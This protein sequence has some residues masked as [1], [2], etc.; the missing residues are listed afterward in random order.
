MWQRLKSLF[1]KE[2]LCDEAFHESLEML[3]R[4]RVMFHDAV[5]SLR[6]K[7]SPEVDIYARD[8]MINRF[9]RRVRRMIVSHLAIATNPDITS[10]LVLTA[11]IIDI[12]R[13]GDFTKNI[14]E[15][16]SMHAEA[17]DGGE[18]DGEIGEI[19]ETVRGI[20]DDLIPALDES[21]M[22]RARRI[23]GD[24][25]VLSDR[26]E[27]LLESLIGGG[28]MADSPGE[29]V[30]AALYLRYLKRVSA[31]LKNVASSIVNPYY[32][33]GFREK[34]TDAGAP[35]GAPVEP[36]EGEEP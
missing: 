31:H 18:L 16:A 13:I 9:E 6:T 25:Q 15:L 3:G 35:S 17:F 4:S 14:V 5:A 26:V 28:A 11:I 34:K 21:D 36:Q 19:E 22:D 27:E 20:F 8:R 2:S 12:E 10:S 33:I 29:A 23:I 1:S 7:G 32:R 30:T 24:H